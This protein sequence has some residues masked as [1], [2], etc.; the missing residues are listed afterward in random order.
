MERRGEGGSVVEVAVVDDGECDFGVERLLRAG[1]SI[2]REEGD[3]GEDP[4]GGGVDVDE[5]IEGSGWARA[6]P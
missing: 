5:T 2:A 6:A 1:H 3:G 4:P